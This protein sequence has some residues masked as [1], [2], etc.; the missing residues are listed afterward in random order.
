MLVS[1]IQQVTYWCSHVH[2]NVH[3]YNLQD[4]NQTSCICL[5]RSTCF[6]KLEVIP[7]VIYIPLGT[8]SI[9]EIVAHRLCIE[10]NGSVADGQFSS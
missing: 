1:V 8:F 9:A 3:G 6:N 2:I 10:N 5:V 4:Y 7:A